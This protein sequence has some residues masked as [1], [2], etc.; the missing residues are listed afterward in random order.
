[1]SKKLI[2][3]LALVTLIVFPIPAF[4][5]RYFIDG[6]QP[7]QL[8]EPANFNWQMILL[9]IEFGICYALI[10]LLLIRLPIFRK[11][12]MQVEKMVKN[13]KL[14]VPEGIFISFC[15]GFGEEILFRA[16]IQAYLGV[17]LTSIIFIGIHGYF[18]I[19]KPKN[20]LYGI[21]LLPFILCLSYGFEEWG[22]WFA[23]AAHFAYDAVLFTAIIRDQQISAE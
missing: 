12:P 14:S 7:I 1:M 11:L 19:R 3:G 20:S 6:I 22:L 9:G 4:I 13:M 21:V 15:A 17:P 16:G 2:L 10:S 23:I 8:I 18:S 5:A